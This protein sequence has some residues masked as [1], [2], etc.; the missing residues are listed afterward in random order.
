ML[1]AVTWLGALLQ[2]IASHFSLALSVACGV[3]AL[4]ASV[5]SIK[6]SRAKEAFY[7]K[8]TSKPRDDNE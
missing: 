2:F 7:E 6:A 8:A 5:Y 4:V 1:A 3:A